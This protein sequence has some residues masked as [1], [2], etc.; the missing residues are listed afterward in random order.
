M[1]KL[2]DKLG[3]EFAM[4]TPFHAHIAVQLT[5]V[6]FWF[7]LSNANQALNGVGFIALMTCPPFP[8]NRLLELNRM[9]L[10]DRFNVQR[11]ATSVQP[12]QLRHGQ[13]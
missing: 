11:V 7:V 6:L 8:N 3:L 2:W 9:C 5:L 13:H 4:L 10:L 12:Q 1:S